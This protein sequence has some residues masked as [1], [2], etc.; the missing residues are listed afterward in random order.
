MK[1]S[2]FRKNAGGFTLVELM[3]VVIIVGILI[4]AAV[5]MYLRYTRR[6]LATEAQ[7]GVG[8]IRTAEQIYHTEHGVYLAVAAGTVGNSP[9]AGLDLD[10]T[11]NK[12]F[13]DSAF[14]VS[15]AG[16]GSTFTA[17]ANGSIS[18]APQAA[19]V[20]Q[21][22]VQMVEDGLMRETYDNATTWSGWH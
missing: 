15:I 18:T 6:A 5:P 7:A 10:F 22:R 2:R 16:G 4:A 19:D 17:T 13:D 9:P 8:S 14:S 12:Y 1:F 11:N 21:I 3:V 20:A